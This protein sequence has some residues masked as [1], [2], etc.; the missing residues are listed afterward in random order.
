[1][2]ASFNSVLGNLQMSNQQL[3][4]QHTSN[5]NL[6]GN[7]NGKAPARSIPSSQQL[8]NDPANASSAG[9]TTDRERAVAAIKESEKMQN[10]I[11]FLVE[12]GVNIEQMIEGTQ[13]MI[14]LYDVWEQYSEKAVKDT[15][16]Q[17]IK[18]RGLHN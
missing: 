7:S 17:C 10:L 2:S 13:V 6:Y 14:S 15:V 4:S 11:K 16:A 3:G 5:Q 8:G 9:F 18:T 1:M 12:S